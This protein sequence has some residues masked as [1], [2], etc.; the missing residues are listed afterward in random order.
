M[1][2]SEDIK[3]ENY[4]IIE[5]LFLNPNY[6]KME[7]SIEYYKSIAE[8]L[9]SKN[10]YYTLR[11]ISI[12]DAFFNES[13]TENEIINKVSLIERLLVKEHGNIENQFILKVGIILKNG[14]FKNVSDVFKRNC[15]IFYKEQ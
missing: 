11:L 6:K 5:N 9:N 13:S 7:I 4:D 15:Y 14:T 1:L 12:I 3:I 8:L 2:S 10:I